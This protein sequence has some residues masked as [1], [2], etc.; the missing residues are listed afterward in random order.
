MYEV[1][2]SNEVRFNYCRDDCVATFAPS[3]FDVFLCCPTTMR[4]AVRPARSAH[5][6]LYDRYVLMPSQTETDGLR[7]DGLVREYER[8]TKENDWQ[9]PYSSGIVPLRL[10]KRRVYEGE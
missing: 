4:V 1:M 3:H 10:P 9:Q 5:R 6:S 7:A 8:R 2:A